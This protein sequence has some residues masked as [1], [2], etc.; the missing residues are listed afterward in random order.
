M[1]KGKDRYKTM[2]QR[3]FGETEKKTSERER[4]R[5]CVI[6]E[7]SLQEYRGGANE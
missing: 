4:E 2:K 3:K 5:E 7:A 1:K 6:L